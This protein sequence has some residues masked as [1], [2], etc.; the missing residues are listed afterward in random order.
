MVSGPVNPRNANHAAPRD[1][2]LQPFFSP[3]SRPMKS[4]IQRHTSHP[5][6][7]PCG[8]D[9]QASQMLREA[10]PTL[11]YEDAKANGIC[12]RRRLQ[13]SESLRRT[14]VV[15]GRE[16]PFK[17]LELNGKLPQ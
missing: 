7:L 17:K 6:G 14:L 5:S 15:M 3:Y 2:L 1:P 4:P 16:E 13:L 12:R 10:K 8:P 9:R 11:M